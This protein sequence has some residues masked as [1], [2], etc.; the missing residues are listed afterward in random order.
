V[1]QAIEPSEAQLK[2]PNDVLIGT[3]KVGGILSERDPSQ[4]WAVVGVGLNVALAIDEAPVELRERIASLQLHR[5]AIEPL[6]TKLLQ[7]LCELLDAEDAAIISAF[8]ERD[9]LKGQTVKWN[10]GEGIA[11]GI[12]HRGQLLVRTARR[13]QVELDAGEVTLSNHGLR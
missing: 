13:K 9:A 3:R 6:L 8:G 2:W 11:Q 5:S 1:A 12:N 4:D 10:E 7:T